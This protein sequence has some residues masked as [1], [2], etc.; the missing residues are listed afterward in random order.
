M[1]QLVRS[2]FE[3]CQH[4]GVRYSI[5]KSLENLASQLEGKGD[6]DVVFDPSQREDVG[7]ILA[8]HSFIFDSGS[9]ATVGKDVLVY[10][11][12]DQPAGT[13]VSLH[14]HFGCRFG[15]KTHKECRYAFESEMFVDQVDYDG[16][17]RLC[18]GHFFAIRLLTVAVRETEKDDFVAE[19]GG[20]YLAGLP[21]K[22][23]I[24][25]S[26]R[27][28][29]Y[30]GCEPRELMEQLSRH[31]AGA[32]H[33]YRTVVG[34]A[35][36]QDDPRQRYSQH[37]DEHRKKKTLR[38]KLVLFLNLGRNKLD[39]PAEIVIT[40]P[41]GA[42]KSTVCD[43]LVKQFSKI[44]PT[45]VIYL[46]RR[47]WSKPNTLVNTMRL[48]PYWSH[49]F[50]P[51]WPLSSTAE[52][53]LRVAKGKILT[54]LGRFVLYDR[55]LYDSVLKF[56]SGY[57]LTGRIARRISARMARAHGDVCVFLYADP[58]VAMSRKPAGK[59]STE[60]LE[61][62]QKKFSSILPES[63]EPTDSSELSAHDIANGIVARYFAAAK[64]WDRRI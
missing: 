12:F 36:D 49:L 28:R 11:G 5:W 4:V 22:D 34:A 56:D 33:P 1:L 30:F 19:I 63:Y 14:V 23:D 6:I 54:R 39:R 58:A 51:L 48:K 29:K 41:D 59:Y 45:S 27:I 44:G 15:S 24:I 46:G 32:L 21:E 37:V 52:L 43:L 25:L 55:S 31:G 2:F 40:G 17:K 9:P 18:D 57:G 8:S 13:Y 10:R 3:D 50:G 26:S 64:E 47:E 20:R 53:L 42:G 62:M 35:L 60:Y 61:D 16:I 38:Q 7:R